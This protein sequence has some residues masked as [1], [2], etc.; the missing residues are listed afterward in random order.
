MT[1]EDSA[2]EK[3]W[4]PLVYGII[5]VTYT[6]VMLHRSSRC[7]RHNR[8]SLSCSA[9]FIYGILWRACLCLVNFPFVFFRLCTDRCNIIFSFAKV[10]EFL[11]SR[12]PSDPA[13][14]GPENYRR[15][16]RIGIGQSPGPSGTRTHQTVTGRTGMRHQ[17]QIHIENIDRAKRDGKRLAVDGR[18]P[19]D[20][21]LHELLRRR[22]AQPSIHTDR[23]SLF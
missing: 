22:V 17:Y 23:S 21:Q 9:Q 14:E 15:R 20:D 5:K 13:E 10:A 12:R 16:R 11:L 18:V 8:F 1:C 6:I 3:V 2:N 19:G 7:T 4:E